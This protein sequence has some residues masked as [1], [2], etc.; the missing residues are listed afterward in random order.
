[1]GLR[2]FWINSDE[3]ELHRSAWYHHTIP[4]QESLSPDG[5]RVHWGY[6]PTCLLS[7]CPSL[8]IFLPTED[9]TT[10]VP[11][12]SIPSSLLSAQGS[13]FLPDSISPTPLHTPLS[14]PARPSFPRCFLL[15]PSCFP[16]RAAHLSTETPNKGADVILFARQLLRVLPELWLWF[17]HSLPSQAFVERLLLRGKDLALYLS[18][19]N[20][21]GDCK[22]SEC[23]QLPLSFHSPHFSTF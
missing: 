16:Q 10:L 5:V 13:L 1:M 3:K 8:G 11:L 4:L 19:V 6:I 7:C 15:Q 22:K 14:S 12:G 20:Q 9:W 17:F 21:K 18:V 2:S 23:G